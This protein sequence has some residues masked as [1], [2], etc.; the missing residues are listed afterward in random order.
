ML[1]SIISKLVALGADLNSRSAI[2][3]AL[4]VIGESEVYV[5]Y[6]YILVKNNA[7]RKE[8]SQTPVKKRLVFLP[9]CLRNSKKCKAELTEYGYICKKCGS[10]SIFEIIKYAESL[11]YDKIFIVPGGSM[12]YKIIREYADKKIA[13]LGVACLPELCEASE[14]LSIKGIAHQSVP[15]RKTGCVDTEVDVDEV[16]KKLALGI[17]KQS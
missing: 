6:I 4:N 3:K 8:W 9:Q 15:L 2:K 12:V 5:D 13:A 7:F 11:G 16:K 14:R 10:C 17:T 1:E